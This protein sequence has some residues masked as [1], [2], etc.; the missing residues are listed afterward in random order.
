MTPERMRSDCTAG[1]HDHQ[2][3]GGFDGGFVDEHD[4]NVVFNPVDAVAIRAFEGFGILAM[5]EGL[6][7]GRTDQ[8]V[9]QIFG[10]HGGN[11]TRGR[12]DGYLQC[13]IFYLEKE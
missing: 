5:F 11:C 13:K 8:D 2:T 1:G 3:L 4:G 10:D 6:F 7:A 12:D 9:E